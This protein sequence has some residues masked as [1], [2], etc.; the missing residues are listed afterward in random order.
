MQNSLIEEYRKHH[1]QIEPAELR[2]TLQTS[3]AAK[4]AS[5]DRDAW[6]F[7]GNDIEPV[8]SP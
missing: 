8:E 5:L 6:M 3:L 4:A 7:E 1:Q 2:R